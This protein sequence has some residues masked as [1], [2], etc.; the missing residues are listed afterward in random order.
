MI[1]ASTTSVTTSLLRSLIPGGSHTYSKGADQFPSN[2]PEAIVKGTGGRVLGTDERWYIDWGLGLTSVSLGHAHPDVCAAVSRAILD[3]VNFP[4]PSVLEGQAAERF[5]QLLGR[6]GDMVKF[7][8]NGSVA[9]TAA[10][11]LARAAT[12]RRFVAVPYEHPFFSYDDWFIGTTSAT[13][14]IPEEH[15]T[16]TLRFHYNDLASLQALFDEHSDDIAT[17][18]LEPVKFDEPVPGFLSGIQDLCRRHGAV[19]TLDETVTG[20]KWAMRGGQEYFGLDPDLSVWGKGL[21]NGFSACALSGR[22]EI[23]ALGGS[24]DTGGRVFLISTTHGAESGPLAAMM[25][26]L[27]IFIRDRVI[28]SNWVHGADLK[29]RLLERIAAHGLDAPLTVMGYPCLLL[30]MWRGLPEVEALRWKTLLLQELIAEGLLFQGVM[31]LTPAHHG[32]LCDETVQAFDRALARVAAAWRSGT[33]AGFL[34]GPAIKP[35]FRR[36]QECMKTRCGRIHAD[37]PREA[38]CG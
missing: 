32:A 29:R 17:V 28:E 27:D 30:V 14:G 23:M 1:D 4:R 21:A 26:T 36:F 11:K 8:K 33:T 7:C 34:N 25:A 38:C 2:A 35:V 9:T 3:G 24:N 18:M 13:L 10:I 20:V 31:T 19:F 16:L 22:R 15:R 6:P 12:G 37:E 5:V